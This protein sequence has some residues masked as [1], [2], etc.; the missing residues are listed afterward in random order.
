MQTR[1]ERA[2]KLER[3][4]LSGP[5]RARAG[6]NKITIRQRSFRASLR[7]RKCSQDAACTRCLRQLQVALHH[8]HT[9]RP[10]SRG[11]KPRRRS[12]ARIAKPEDAFRTSQRGYDRRFGEP[13]KVDSEIKASRSQLA[14]GC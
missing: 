6:Q 5:S 9:A 1:A 7:N 2:V 14:P 4:F 10:D 8:M 3:P 11:I 12:F 13:L